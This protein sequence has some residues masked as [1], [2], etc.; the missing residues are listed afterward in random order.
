MAKRGLLDGYKTYNPEVE[1][2]GDVKDWGK[3]FEN[4]MGIGEANSVL[5]DN[6]PVVILGL[7]AIPATLAELKR[8]YHKLI[9]QYQ[10]AF[11]FNATA[12]QQIVAKKII[13]AYSILED[14]LQRRNK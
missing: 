14:L 10:F 9:M 2:Y 12:E 6:D 8:V 7:K 11:Q 1:G 13:A 4:R 3:A 5:Q